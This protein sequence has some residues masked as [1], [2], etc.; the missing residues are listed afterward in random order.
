MGNAVKAWLSDNQYLERYAPDRYVKKIKVAGVDSGVY[1]FYLNRLFGSTGEVVS[2]HAGE[3]DSLKGSLPK[4]EPSKRIF[5][6]F[7]NSKA[8]SISAPPTSETPEETT[9]IEQF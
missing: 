9:H 8:G 7:S 4:C 6:R 1:S 5:S 2:S 3:S